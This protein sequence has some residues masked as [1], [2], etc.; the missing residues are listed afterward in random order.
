MSSNGAVRHLFGKGGPFGWIWGKESTEEACSELMGTREFNNQLQRER[1]RSCRSGSPFTFILLDVQVADTGE[2]GEH[3]KFLEV[4]AAVVCNRSRISD[5][6]GWYAEDGRTC[7]GLILTDTTG[8]IAAKVIRSI[9]DSFAQKAKRVVSRKVEPPPLTC[10][11]FVSP[12][13][14]NP[15]TSV[16]ATALQYRIVDQ[17]GLL[18][19]N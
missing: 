16:P 14:R 13:T 12:E 2:K 3:A 17:E 19:L 11:I 8:E 10:K 5:I 7:L 6:K 9:E 15:V 1:A 4:L 18:K